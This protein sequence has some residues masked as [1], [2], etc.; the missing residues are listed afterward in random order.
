MLIRS[1][2]NRNIGIKE[3]LL[4]KPIRVDPRIEYQAL[5]PKYVELDVKGK[6]KKLTSR[7]VSLDLNINT[8]HSFTNGCDKTNMNK[9]VQSNKALKSKITMSKF[10]LRVKSWKKLNQ[11]QGNFR[12]RRQLHR[13]LSNSV[14]TE[15]NIESIHT[16]VRTIKEAWLE[17]DSYCCSTGNPSNIFKNEKMKLFLEDIKPKT[18]NNCQQEDFYLT[19]QIFTKNCKRGVFSGPREQSFRKNTLAVSKFKTRA[20]EV[21]SKCLKVKGRRM[22]MPEVKRSNK[23]QSHMAI[24]I[25]RH[26]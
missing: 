13:N 14:T 9:S 20:Q 5:M 25:K 1:I 8:S 4:K 15:P 10:N 16:Q 2:K 11:S 12:R 21:I 23:Q 17:D 24:S 6:N 3:K 18:N 7:E 19:N 22:S 26:L